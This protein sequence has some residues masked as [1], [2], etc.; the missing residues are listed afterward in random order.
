M[1]KNRKQNHRTSRITIIRAILLAFVL[2]TVQTLSLIHI[3]GCAGN[4]DQPGDT[5]AEI[6]G[7]GLYPSC[8]VTATGTSGGEGAGGFVGMAVKGSNSDT[9]VRIYDCYNR[10]LLYTSSIRKRNWSSI[11]WIKAVKSIT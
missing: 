7:L 3:F 9:P 5:S 1:N 4:G 8:S 11:F 6:V 2:C 10:C